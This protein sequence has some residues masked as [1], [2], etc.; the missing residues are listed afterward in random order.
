MKNEK[1]GKKEK[2]GM[3]PPLGFDELNSR[4]TLAVF[5]L[6][7]QQSEILSLWARVER[8]ERRRGG[9]K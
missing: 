6:D 9:L 3:S 2:A 7:Q 5:Q 8:L 1:L 4:L